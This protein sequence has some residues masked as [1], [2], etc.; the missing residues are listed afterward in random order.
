MLKQRKAAEDLIERRKKFID[1][2][3]RLKEEALA[4]LESQGYEVRGKTPAEIRD[5][6]RKGRRRQLRKTAF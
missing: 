4:K 6:I 3:K 2:L 5:T 1:D